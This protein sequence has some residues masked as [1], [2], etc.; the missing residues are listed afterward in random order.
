MG[1]DR[2]MTF[3]TAQLPL[4]VFGERVIDGNQMPL[5]V[6]PEFAIFDH[7]VMMRPA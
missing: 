2:A 4:C 6:C 1:T 5:L 3:R 7:A